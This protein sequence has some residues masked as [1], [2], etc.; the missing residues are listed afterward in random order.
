MSTFHSVRTEQLGCCPSL[1]SRST[2]G[3]S[4]KRDIWTNEEGNVSFCQTRLNDICR[5][6]QYWLQRGERVSQ[7]SISPLE[8]F[9]TEALRSFYC[10]TW[11]CRSAVFVYGGLFVWPGRRVMFPFLVLNFLSGTGP[12]GHQSSTSSTSQTNYN[13]THGQ[14]HRADMWMKTEEEQSYEKIA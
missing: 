11:C 6:L 3:V 9:K 4:H 13:P 8:L 7:L 1:L 14:Q 5:L 10:F 2:E 12:K